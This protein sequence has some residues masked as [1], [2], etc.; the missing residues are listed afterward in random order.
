MD[1]WKARAHILQALTELQQLEWG[2]K[3]HPE[4]ENS[5]GA[6]GVKTAVDTACKALSTWAQ[7]AGVYFGPGPTDKK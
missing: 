1:K 5:M 3:E 4:L 2:L 7:E 6:S